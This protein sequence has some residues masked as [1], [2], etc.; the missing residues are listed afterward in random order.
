MS[1]VAREVG[2]PWRCGM[3]GRPVGERRRPAGSFKVGSKHETRMALGN[4]GWRHRSRAGK[5]FRSP[6]MRKR[7]EIMRVFFFLTAQD[8]DGWGAGF[9][10][11]GGHGENRAGHRLRHPRHD[12]ASSRSSSASP[13][14]PSRFSASTS[15]RRDTKLEEK[16]LQGVFRKKLPHGS[17][18]LAML[19]SQS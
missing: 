8:R 9:P 16:N 4:P 5:E 19:A 7:I 2:G 14:C 12:A 6:I 11:S 17:G 3:L 18:Q 15:C 1:V 10:A 13:L